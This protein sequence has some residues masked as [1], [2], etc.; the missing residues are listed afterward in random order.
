MNWG[1]RGDCG[2]CEG[3]FDCYKVVTTFSPTVI[4][5]EFTQEVGNWSRI[6]PPNG[7]AALICDTPGG[8]LISKTTYNPSS[9][10][11]AFGAFGGE[12]FGLLFDWVDPNNYHCLYVNSSGYSLERNFGYTGSWTLEKVTAGIPVTVSS[13]NTGAMVEYQSSGNR[14]VILESF[15]GRHDVV[16]APTSVTDDDDPI[17]SNTFTT[18]IDRQTQTMDLHGGNKWGITLRSPFALPDNSTSEPRWRHTYLSLGVN[19]RHFCGFTQTRQRDPGIL[20]YYSP[21][22]DIYIDMGSSFLSP[23]GCENCAALQGVYSMASFGFWRSEGFGCS[24][25]MDYVNLDPYITAFPY[26]VDSNVRWQVWVGPLQITSGAP[27]Y[28]GAVYESDSLPLPDDVMNPSNYPLTL[29][30]KG[31]HVSRLCTGEFPSTISLSI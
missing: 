31:Q 4:D 7:G 11:F 27:Y 19:E 18:I 28:L 5:D 24:D 2:C 20:D 12:N 10:E 17:G 21:I 13:G 9:F 16:I 1:W 29:H 23:L 14:V 30:L 6:F 15:F 8:Q 26:E 25:N 22:K 3:H